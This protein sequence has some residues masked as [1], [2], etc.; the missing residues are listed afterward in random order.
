MRLPLVFHI[1]PVESQN[2][3]LFFN[4]RTLS[5]EY[6]GLDAA[7]LS[8]MKTW[9]QNRTVS[10]RFKADEK[11]QVTEFDH[12][13]ENNQ[14]PDSNHSMRKT[15]RENCV[16]VSLCLDYFSVSSIAPRPRRWMIL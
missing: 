14:V 9:A 13:S 12:L 4:T 2:N 1:P 16:P 10:L 11:C 15:I 3:P 5:Q 7:K 6:L 8:Q